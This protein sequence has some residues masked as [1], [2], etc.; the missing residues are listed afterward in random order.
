[1][2]LAAREDAPTGV[3]RFSLRSP[4]HGYAFHCLGVPLFFDLLDKAGVAEIAAGAPGWPRCGA[5]GP[6][7]AYDTPSTVLDVG[8]ISVLPLLQGSVALRPAGGRAGPSMQRRHGTAF[9]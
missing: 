7:K 9:A 5:A 3:Y 1:M 2:F 4:V 8:Y 6:T